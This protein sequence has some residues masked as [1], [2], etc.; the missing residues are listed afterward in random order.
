MRGLQYAKRQRDIETRHIGQARPGIALDAARQVEGVADVRRRDQFTKPR[1][2]RVIKAPSEPDAEQGIDD[3]G[4]GTGRMDILHRTNP[5]GARR[6]GTFCPARSDRGDPNRDAPVA[7]PFGH[8]K[9]VA[10]VIARSAQHKHGTLVSDPPYLFGSALAG[11]AHEAVRHGARVKERL[12]CRPCFGDRE[13]WL[14]VQSHGRC[15]SNV[16][17]DVRF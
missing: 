10:A 7:Q 9:S 5:V 8:D 3:L 14:A 1:C 16:G 13:D 12:F 4:G 15:L 17:K 6:V 2:Q 11:P